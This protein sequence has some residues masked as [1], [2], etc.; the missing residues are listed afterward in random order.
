MNSVKADMYTLINSDGPCK[1]LCSDDMKPSIYNIYHN[2]DGPGLLVW[3]TLTGAFLSVDSSDARML[4]EGRANQLPEEKR[5]VYIEKGLIVPSSRDELSELERE[6][7]SRLQGDGPGG[8]FYRILVTTGCNASCPYC[9][10]G[11]PEAKNMDEKMADHV[12]MFIAARQHRKPVLIEWFGGEPLMEHN[13]I[14]GICGSLREAGCIYSS[15]ITTNGSL[16]DRQLINRARSEWNLRDAQITLDGIGKVHDSIK[17]LP[18]GSFRDTI[19]AIHELRDADINVRIRINHYRGQEHF[20]L[21]GWIAEEFRG[22]PGITAYAEPGYAGGE[23]YPLALMKEVL[24]LN[25]ILKE[26]GLIYR[27]GSFLPGRRRIGCFACDPRNYTI[28]PD[29]K[30]YNCSHNMS[31]EQCIGDVFS[32][33][34]WPEERPFIRRTFADKCRDC[35]LLPVCMGGCRSGELRTAAMTQCPP[36]RNIVHELMELQYKDIGTAE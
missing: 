7:S 20:Q 27:K 4:S 33:I 25:L 5:A 34:S 1:E 19:Q 16:W 22:D 15:V 2:S 18:P 28:A 30:I 31:E 21:A 26:A 23:E 13:A 12:A 36:F 17:G 10:E 24:A 29:G 11:H 8:G 35:E 6:H 3:N 9:Y 32:G 14:S